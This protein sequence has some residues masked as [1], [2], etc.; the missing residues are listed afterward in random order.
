[1]PASQMPDAL[2][3]GHHTMGRMPG[4]TNSCHATMENPWEMPANQM[5][6]ALM[7]GHHGEMSYQST[8]MGALDETW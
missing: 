6:D 1:M 2:M 3:K 7:K 4:G 5:P 8:Q